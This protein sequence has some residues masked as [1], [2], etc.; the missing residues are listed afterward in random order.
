MSVINLRG[1]QRIQPVLLT[2]PVVL[3]LA[4]APLSEANPLSL[5]QSQ[6]PGSLLAV[7]E[8]GAENSGVVAGVPGSAADVSA[9]MSPD[10]GAGEAAVT[11]GRK[12]L[13]VFFSIGVVVDVLLVAAFLVWAVGQWRKTKK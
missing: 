11:D 1:G 3:M 9:S 13:T 4:V 12:D 8:D 7:A 6:S 2:L 5:Q 10:S